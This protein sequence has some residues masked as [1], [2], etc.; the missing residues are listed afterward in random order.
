MRK[1]ADNDILIHDAIVL[2]L[3][4]MY[5]GQ[6]SRLLLSHHRTIYH[7]GE[8]NRKGSHLRAS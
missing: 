6:A 8:V 5:S 1:N 3:L 2:L 7:Q 4:L